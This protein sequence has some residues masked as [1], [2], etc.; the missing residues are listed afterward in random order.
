MQPMIRVLTVIAIMAGAVSETEARIS[1]AP[2][3]APPSVEPR[4]RAA[5]VVG[6]A[7]HLHAL[8]GISRL[9]GGTRAAGTPGDRATADYVADRLRNAGY[10]VSR[11]Q[12]RVPYFRTLG[13]S[14]VLRASGPLR[15][16]RRTVQPLKFTRGRSVSGPVRRIRKGC[17]PAEAAT[18]RPGDIA[19]VGR[20]GCTFLKKG[21]I[22][23]RGGAVAILI[24]GRPHERVVNP[25]LGRPGLRIPALFVAH[26]A[27]AVLRMGEWVRVEV[28]TLSEMR[29]SDNVLAAAP[30]P[31]HRRSAI[32]GAHLDSVP[33]S[34]G[35]NDNGSGVAAALD[36]AERLA[37]KRPAP[38]RVKF[39]FWAAEE[40]GLVG[41]G[42][43][44]RRLSP[45]ARRSVVAY[46]NLDM[47][48]SLRPRPIVYSSRSDSVSL[49]LQRLLLKDL[50]HQGFSARAEAVRTGSDHV[51]FARVGIPV[52]G[53]LTR[54]ERSTDTCYHRPCDDLSNVDVAVTQ[55][56]A[57]AARPALVRTRVSHRRGR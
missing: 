7:A 15:G 49:R 10:E 3:A 23:A 6:V 51:P 32:V 41:S 42:H 26:E 2:S 52:A 45:A 28:R 36:V 55:T 1:T 13:T 4:K 9:H 35:L 24:A 29:V 53:L 33:E 56:M 19:L 38:T 16:G 21:R 37:A 12:V 31:S 8:D 20:G 14:R 46:L 57:H 40:V 39:A 54:T 44:V 48:G 17:T 34:P 50:R 11:Q 5:S 18:L 43:Y 30:G 22:A 25:T 47:V 27:A